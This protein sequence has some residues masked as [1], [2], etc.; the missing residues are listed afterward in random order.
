VVFYPAFFAAGEADRLLLYG[1]AATAYTYSV[2]EHVPA[3]WRPAR[4]EVKRVVEPVC[5]V[6]F[7]GV[8]LTATAP[9]GTA[10]PGTATTR[11]SSA[12][13]RSSPR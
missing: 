3:P 10:S 8:L 7:N 5:G 6:A 2:I 9:A 1:D 13:T 4:L 12:P 11:R